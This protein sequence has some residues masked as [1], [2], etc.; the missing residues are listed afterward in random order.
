MSS[1]SISLSGKT[2]SNTLHNLG[3]KSSSL[4]NNDPIEVQKLKIQILN[5]ILLPLTN[6]NWE[7]LDQNNFI[8]DIVINKLNLYYSKYKLSDLLIYKEVIRSIEN[9]INEHGAFINL[10]NKLYSDCNDGATLVY[11]TTMIK[12]RPE[13]ELYNLIYGRPIKKNGE[14]YNPDILKELTELIKV[15]NIDFNKIK[16]LITNNYKTP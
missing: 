12:L 6:N 7:Y 10:Q 11:R 14:I 2:I 1:T 9:I 15:E 16:F 5:K 4:I 8:I 3:G 13:Y